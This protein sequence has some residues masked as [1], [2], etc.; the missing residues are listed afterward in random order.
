[1]I[2]TLPF[3][4]L[5]PQF[6]PPSSPTD[7][8]DVS[9]DS[10]TLLICLCGLAGNGAV[11]CFLQRNS[12]T[13]YII[14]LA[15]ANFTFLH[16]AV[17]SSL[18]YLLEDLSCSTVVSL[19]YL[20]C[21]LLLSLFSYNLGL[22]LLTAISIERCTSILCPFWYRCHRPK[23]LS[24]VVCALLW[25]FSI[26]VIVTVTSLC[27]SQE[28]EHCQ[29]SLISMYTLNLFIFTPAMLISSTI[30]FIKVKCGSHEQQPKSY[31]IVIFLV[32]PF[33]LIF[34]LPLSLSNFLQQLDYTVV[35]SQIVFLLACIHSTIN[36][37]IYFLAGRC[38]RRC[39]VRSLRLSL[40]R[41]FEE[42]EES[43]ARGNDPAMDTV[44]PDC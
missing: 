9:I 12:T 42:T 35:S 43:N 26:A 25:A 8:M 17:P 33:F 27:L 3:P 4:S 1:N 41:I 32:V 15:F 23:R 37:F 10:V 18:L 2:P 7:V 22:Y 20:R 40:Q 39:S 21:L 6:P 28:H 5:T 14:N 13:L 34:A 38:W 44:L 31:D 16:F 19:N 29:M 11:L 36:P 30:L 24:W